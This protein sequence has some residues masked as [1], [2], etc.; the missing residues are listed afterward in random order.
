MRPRGKPIR[1]LNP[2]TYTSCVPPE[3]KTYKTKNTNNLFIDKL[4]INAQ[5]SPYSLYIF[6]VTNTDIKKLNQSTSKI[7]IHKNHQ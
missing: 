4:K 2:D 5:S 1:S 7:Y 3:V 6:S